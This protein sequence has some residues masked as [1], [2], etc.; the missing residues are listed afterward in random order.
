M[1]KGHVAKAL[2]LICY[3]VFL[4]VERQLEEPRPPG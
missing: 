4:C 1:Y 3:L 2:A